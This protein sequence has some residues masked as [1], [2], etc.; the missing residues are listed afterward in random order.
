MFDGYTLG[1]ILGAQYYD[2]LLK[3]QPNIP[4]Q[5]SQGEFSP[6]FNW[7]KAN[8]WSHGRAYDTHTLTKRITGGAVSVQPLIDYLNVKFGDIY[9][10]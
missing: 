6:L 7:L 9:N 10:L 2:A 1:N 4:T 8:I 3:E 5:I